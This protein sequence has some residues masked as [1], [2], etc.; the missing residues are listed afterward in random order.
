MTS[1]ASKRK[2]DALPGILLSEAMRQ[3]LVLPNIHL[4]DSFSDWVAQ[5]MPR[6]PEEDK[7]PSFA[8]ELPVG[9]TDNHY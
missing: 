6:P 1:K 3:G 7:R 9:E 2:R 4:S 8:N 5:N